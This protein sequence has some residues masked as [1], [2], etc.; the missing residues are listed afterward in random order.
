MG[1]IGEGYPNGTKY[2]SYFKG[3]FVDIEKIN[4]YTYSMTLDYIN[5]ENEIGKQWIEDDILY[6][7]SEA[8]G[9]ENGHEF[10]IY[11]PDTPK[12]ELSEE[13]LSWKNIKNEEE[14]LE[15]YGIYNKNEGYGFFN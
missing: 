10:L 14:I 11:T 9:L 4:D 8:Y 6:I 12:N 7:A 2:I 13:F 1:E 3:K 5:Y 15:T